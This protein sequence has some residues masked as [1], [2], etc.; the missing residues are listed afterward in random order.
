MSD[1]RPARLALA[2]EIIR[3]ALECDIH[4]RL[5]GGLAF[6]TRSESLQAVLLPYHFN[7][8][9]DLFASS[10]SRSA[11]EHLLI[12]RFGLVR[13]PFLAEIPGEVHGRFY[14]S[15]SV[16]VCD[17]SYGRF[18][19]CHEFVIDSRLCADDL[20]IPLAE[21]LLSKLQIVEATDKDLLDICALLCTHNFGVSDGETINLPIILR[22]SSKSWGLEHTLR[23]AVSRV[24]QFAANCSLFSDT[25]VRAIAKRLSELLHGLE[26]SCKSIAWRVRGLLGTTFSWHN[27]VREPPR[28]ELGE[29]MQNGFREVLSSGSSSDN[30]SAFIIGRPSRTAIFFVSDI[31]GS[32]ICFRKFLAMSKLE[33][34]SP[35]VLIVGGD[36]TGKF[37][38]PI[39]ERANESWEA[40]RAD[41]SVNLRTRT[42]LAEYRK[43]L[44]D[45]GGY[46]W[47][48]DPEQFQ[49]FHQ[50][51]EYR[52]G[53]DEELRTA[54]LRN[55]VKLADEF[56]QGTSCSV[57]MNAGNDDPLYIDSVLRESKHLIVPEGL[58]IELEGGLTMISTGVANMTPWK[59]P[60]DVEDQEV[61]EIIEKMVRQ[62]PEL[63]RCIFNIHCPPYNTLLDQAPKLDRE[64]RIISSGL[65]VQLESVGSRSVREAIERYQPMAGLHGHIHESPAIQYL[66]RTA[67][68]NPGSEYQLGRLNGAMLEIEMGKLMS[69]KQV[70]DDS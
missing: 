40:K 16:P 20:T 61:A 49:S 12:E 7:S 59:C 53:I 8:D 45:R 57:F 32:N 13:D 38:I 29:L 27:D 54:R 51:R 15:K 23:L 6:W 69:I 64:L 63:S 39:I 19:Y 52:S 10:A 41:R 11:V 5:Y 14:D 36:I 68:V 48:C 62:V 24:L 1:K 58:V 18:V 55:W 56:L 2:E 30:S 50:D 70:Q 46:S 47:V 4:L 60:R 31:H 3:S 17:V 66:G 26:H 65:G 44:A 35:N 34:G 28:P 21:L 25:Q 9:I 33:R 43:G 67:C 37:I 22:L 42:E